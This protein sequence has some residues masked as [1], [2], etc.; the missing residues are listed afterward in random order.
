MLT[1]SPGIFIQMLGA[2]QPDDTASQHQ[3]RDHK[4]SQGHVLAGGIGY[5]TD[6]QR[7]HHI[8]KEVND[9][10]V[11]SKCTGTRAWLNHIG[12]GCIAWAGV[13]EQAE[14]SEEDEHPGRGEGR[15]EHAQAAGKG[16]EHGNA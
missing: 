10:D 9:Q 14:A 15:I 6:D 4:E 7:R 3:N 5:D 8:T 1:H 13:E 16:Q 12:E 2:E 11:Q